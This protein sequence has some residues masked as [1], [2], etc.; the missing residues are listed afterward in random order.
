MKAQAGNV[1]AIEDWR[2]RKTTLT[3][4]STGAISLTEFPE[5]LK[6]FRAN[7][8]LIKE[9]NKM[10]LNSLESLD[11]KIY[12]T[13]TATTV[14]VSETIVQPRIGR[15]SGHVQFFLKL[16]ELWRLD[17]ED[18]CK[19]LGYEL[20][21]IKYVE[22]VLSGELPLR[23]RDPKDRIANLVV[24]RKRLDGL[25]KDVDVEN[26]WLR[27]KQTDIG[28]KSPMEL[29]LS[30]SMENLLLVKQFVEFVCGL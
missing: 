21:D 15:L 8:E 13:T 22:Q 7:Q 9:Q 19:L 23:G 24:I 5:L 27:E 29:L 1:I 20:A 10:I 26:E 18:A 25:F 17:V 4:S 2:K 14:K 16:M 12:E 6:Q 3:N 28:N 11:K 30:G